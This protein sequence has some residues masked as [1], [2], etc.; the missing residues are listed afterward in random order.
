MP[1]FLAPLRDQFA[2]EI[3]PLGHVP[4]DDGPRALHRLGG[5]KEAKLA[6]FQFERHIVADVEVQ[7]SPR[8]RGNDNSPA[9]AQL[10]VEMP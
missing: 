6:V 3:A 5:R 4:G 8:I 9:R 1:R 10:A 2:G 7:G